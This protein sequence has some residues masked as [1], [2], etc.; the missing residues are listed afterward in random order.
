MKNRRIKMAINCETDANR[1]SLPT[2]LEKSNQL[3]KTEETPVTEPWPFQDIV[4]AARAQAFLRVLQ[5]EISTQGT[6]SNRI[7]RK[8]HILIL[9]GRR[10]AHSNIEERHHLVPQVLLHERMSAN[11]GW[12]KESCEHSKDPTKSVQVREMQ[13]VKAGGESDV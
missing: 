9:L 5:K 13:T 4:Y 8:T 12:L 7:W 3:L 1:S 10:G 6:C 2:N 11:M